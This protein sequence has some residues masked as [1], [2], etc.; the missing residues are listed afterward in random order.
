[1]IAPA[2]AVASCALALAAAI[3][4]HAEAGQPYSH[5]VE[6]S[7]GTPEME[8]KAPEDSAQP[9][10]KVLFVVCGFDQTPKVGWPEAAYLPN[11]KERSGFACRPSL[12][13]IVELRV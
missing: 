11:L 12:V 5:H 4:T 13:G 6:M 3:D 10:A 9:K 2:V 7:L 1:M 8:G